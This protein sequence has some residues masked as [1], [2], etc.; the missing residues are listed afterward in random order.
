[1]PNADHAKF[2]RSRA[3]HNNSLESFPLVAAALIA[4]SVAGLPSSRMNLAAAALLAIRA[5]YITLYINTT[6]LQFSWFRTAVWFAEKGVQFTILIQAANVFA[7]KAS[8]T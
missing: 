4:G 2:E 7:S 6:T 1:M 8:F 5:L 3:A